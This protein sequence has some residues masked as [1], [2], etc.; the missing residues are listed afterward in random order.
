MQAQAQRP[1][2]TEVILR[3]D[4]D[5]PIYDL[6]GLVEWRC[7]Q[8]LIEQAL[9]CDVKCHVVYWC[10]IQAGDDYQCVDE[11]CLDLPQGQTR[12]VPSSFHFHSETLQSFNCLLTL[13]W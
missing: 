7:G 1:L 8:A 2:R 4:G 13:S 3:L 9:L 6:A 11:A 10:K 5:Q 12:R